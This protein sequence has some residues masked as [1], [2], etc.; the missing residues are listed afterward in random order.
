MVVRK[1]WWVKFSDENM[2]EYVYRET[3]KMAIDLNMELEVFR[4]K[5]YEAIVKD[6]EIRNKIIEYIKKNGQQQ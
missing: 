6:S 1:Y 5:M 2:A 3:Q 4:G